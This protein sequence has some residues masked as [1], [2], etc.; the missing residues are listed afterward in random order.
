MSSSGEDRIREEYGEVCLESDPVN[1]DNP[2]FSSLLGALKAVHTG[3]M[4]MDVLKKYHLSLDEQ[5]DVS[6]ENIE[7][8]ESPP[9]YKEQVEEQ[10]QIALGAIDMVQIT[11]DLVKNY[12]QEPT[13]EK[14]AFCV[15]SLL[16]SQ[17]F[18]NVLN[19]ILDENIRLGK[20]AENEM[21]KIS[22]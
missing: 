8:L 11:L 19:R 18:I 9:D 13:G 6:R 16:K 1:P 20:E 22:D 10:K 12:I 4:G 14:M 21:R 7:N 3:E 2:T 17:G 15:D 5:L